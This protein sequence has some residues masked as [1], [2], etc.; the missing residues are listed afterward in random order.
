[1]TRLAL[2][3]ILS[4]A[5]ALTGASAHAA[6]RGLRSRSFLGN[7][8]QPEVVARTL[9]SVEEEWKAQAGVFVEC[10]A[11]GNDGDSIVNCGDAPKSFAK[12]CSTVVLAVVQGSG[13]DRDVTKE[14]MGDVCTQVALNSWHKEGCL[15]L[16]TA[17]DTAMTADSYENRINFD[18]SALCSKFWARFLEGEKKRLA[19]EQAQREEQERK[20]AEAA[21]EAAKKAQEE[22]AAAAKK[23][24]E[25]A[26]AKAEQQKKDEESR[27]AA[28]AKAAADE[29]A[30]ILEKKKAE[31]EEKKAEAEAVAEAAKK[32]MAEAEAAEKEHKELEAKVSVTKVTTQPPAAKSTPAAA[33]NGTASAQEP[34]SLQAP[35][36]DK[37]AAP[38]AKKPV[39]KPTNT[40]K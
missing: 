31:V 4:A 33:V 40:T 38:V 24:Q 9:A 14:Y 37:E 34:T 21:A 35:K 3:L 1:M 5:G 25:E 39:V 20:A 29:A 7:G 32:K 12:S 6:A 2:A 18:T 16:A 8:M 36:A 11:T 26:A 30:K 10:N 19:E 13:G 28:E 15:N 17:L 22:A 23:A 27:R